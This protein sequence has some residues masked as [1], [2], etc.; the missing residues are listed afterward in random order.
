MAV[1]LCRISGQSFISDNSK[2]NKT[3]DSS[4]I[5]DEIKSKVNLG[6]AVYYSVQKPILILSIFQNNNH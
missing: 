5:Y 2:R 1:I 6:Y 3:N 4:E